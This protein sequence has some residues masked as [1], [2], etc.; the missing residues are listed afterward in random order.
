MK[1]Q[2]QT[3]LLLLA[4]ITQNLGAQPMKPDLW[5][6][7]TKITSGSGEVEKSATLAL[8]PFTKH[9]R[10]QRAAFE[11]KIACSGM[12]L[13]GDNMALKFCITREIALQTDPL[14]REGVTDAGV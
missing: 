4:G 13:D 2:Y 8:E 14:P 5:E 9:A 1:I 6:T 11:A 7:S 10:E 3:A 12:R